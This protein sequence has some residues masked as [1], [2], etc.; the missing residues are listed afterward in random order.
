[1]QRIDVWARPDWRAKVEAQG[2]V[3]HTAGGAPYW[4]EGAAYSFTGAEV[5]ELEKATAELYRLFVQAGEYVVD[6]K[7]YRR[8]GIPEWCD[9]LIEEA[10][11]AEP[12]AL[13]YGR[14]DLGYDGAGP[15]K[16]FEFNCD[17]PTSLL[18]A[19]V[20]QWSWKEE[21]FPDRDQF[22]SLHDKLVAKWAD[23]APALTANAH[24]VHFTCAD[25]STGEDAVTSAYLMDTARIAGLPVRQVLAQDIGWDSGGRQFVDLNNSP[26]KALQHL[27][28]WEW[29]VN[30]SF[31]RHIVDTR[32]R[33]VWI[34][35]IWKMIWS[36]KA[37]LPILWDLNPRHP[38]L[39]WAS[40]TGPVGSDYVEKPV[41]AR[42]G[43]NIRVTKGGQVI[44]QT[45]GAY[46][47]APRIWQGL[48]N[49]PDF[50]GSRPV[51]GCW[52]VDGEPAGMG[53]REDGLVTSNLARFVPHI[54]DG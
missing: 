35:P 26:I 31:A 2:L 14:F 46:S 50:S 23:I 52:V 49:L 22:N 36:N 37:I 43:G 3:W 47:E 32:G 54:I 28:P 44:A 53:I 10:W 45:D 4:T 15:P 51:I 16:L 40:A 7:L 11:K 18:E 34:E 21:V 12:P 27:Y 19:A 1:M 39:L 20:I 25:E 29:L 6:Q 8:F 48:Y 13:N 41:L 17:T 38:N 33:M 24:G 5:A 42:E 9:A 30:E